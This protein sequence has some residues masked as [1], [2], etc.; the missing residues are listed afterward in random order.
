M[1]GL[2]VF[3]NHAQSTEKKQWIACHDRLL[4][5]KKESEELNKR[6][7]HLENIISGT[8]ET[9]KGFKEEKQNDRS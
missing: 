7:R 2:K 6:I 8:T 5:L 1:K 4:E 3:G 9:L